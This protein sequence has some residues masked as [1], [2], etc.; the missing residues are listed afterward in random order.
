M[1]PPSKIFSKPVNKNAIKHQKGVPSSQ[2]FH[3]IPS[4][5]KSGK[6]LKDPPPGF[7][8]SVHLWR[9]E[10]GWKEGGE[11]G[12]KEGK[13]RGEGKRGRKEGNER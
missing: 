10:R 7:S 9:E 6:N 5:L 2:N 4:L 13:E 12:R 8:N 11:R 1:Y 3:Y